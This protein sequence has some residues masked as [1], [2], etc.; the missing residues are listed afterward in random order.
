LPFEYK[1]FDGKNWECLVDDVAESDYDLVLMGALGMGAV[2]DSMVGSVTDRVVRRTRV[3][4]LVIRD[5]HPFRDDASDR[6]VVA[7]DGRPRRGYRAQDHAAR[8]QGLQEGAAVRPPGATLAVDRRPNRG[9][10]RRRNGHGQQQ[11]QPAPAGARQRPTFEPD[12]RPARRCPG[13]SQR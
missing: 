11:R 2:K 7:I 6:I 1:T 8:R 4:T 5:T 13:G 3:D 9:A 12:L 10:L